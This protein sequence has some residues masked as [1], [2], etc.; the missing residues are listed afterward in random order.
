MGL[1][2]AWRITALGTIAVVSCPGGPAE[3]KPV[4][5]SFASSIA[6]VTQIKGPIIAM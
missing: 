5:A 3:A 6:T 1:F 4:F 2:V